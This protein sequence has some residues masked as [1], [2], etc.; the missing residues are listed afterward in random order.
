[1]LRRLSRMPLKWK[2]LLGAQAAA[3][4]ALMARRV[5]PTVFDP[6]FEK[7]VLV[8]T[9]TPKGLENDSGSHSAR[10]GFQINGFSMEVKKPDEP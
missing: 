9:K 3:T 2:V 5:D 6:L 7:R 4:A 1:M 10:D 8:V